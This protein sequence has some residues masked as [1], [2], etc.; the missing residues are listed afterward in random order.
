MDSTLRRMSMCVDS[1]ATNSVTEFRRRESFGMAVNKAA[2]H[3]GICEQG[4]TKGCGDGVRQQALQVP[5]EL[6]RRRENTRISESISGFG[7][8]A[9]LLSIPLPAAA[10]HNNTH[11]CHAAVRM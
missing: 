3:K 8:F 7:K 5:Q 11:D 1:Q 6:A 2:S 10:H 9:F 4:Q